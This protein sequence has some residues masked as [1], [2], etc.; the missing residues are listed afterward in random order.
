MEISSN[1]NGLLRVFKLYQKR[2]CLLKVIKPKEIKN[3]QG[4]G[5]VIHVATSFMDGT[6][7]NGPFLHCW[8]CID[9]KNKF[10]LWCV[11]MRHDEPI[12]EK[13]QT[14]MNNQRIHKPMAWYLWR[15]KTKLNHLQFIWP[16][17]KWLTELSCFLKISTYPR[18]CSTFDIPTSWGS[19]YV[20]NRF[21][22][23]FC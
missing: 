12:L 22:L 3:N 7:A 20:C 15:K 8:N 23:C 17:Q 13:W 19:K 6:F 4:R 21:V 10:F 1:F 14:W 2:R 9:R 5:G 18:S 11:C 16:N